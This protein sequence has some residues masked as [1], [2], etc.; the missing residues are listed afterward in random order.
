MQIYHYGGF[1]Y[2]FSAIGHFPS[3]VG[4]LSMTCMHVLTYVLG[5]VHKHLRQTT[6]VGF[7]SNNGHLYLNGVWLSLYLRTYTKKK[8]A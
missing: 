5:D 2:F 3:D 7:I 8:Y 4:Q 6:S 1:A